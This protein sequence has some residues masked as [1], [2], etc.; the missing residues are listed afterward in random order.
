MEQR[1]KVPRLKTAAMSE[2][3]RDN[4]QWYQGMVQETSHVWEARRHC[5]RPV[6]ILMGWSLQSKQSKLPLDFGK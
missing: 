2:K 5:V 3:G 1:N 6:D 4:W